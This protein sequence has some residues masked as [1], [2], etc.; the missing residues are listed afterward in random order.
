MAGKALLMLKVKI[1][2]RRP[3]VTLHVYT[4]DT[5]DSLVERC[6]FI[7]NLEEK[8]KQSADGGTLLKERLASLIEREIN[9]K[10]AEMQALLP[11]D[12]LH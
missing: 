1:T 6:L 9:N 4:D 12:L 5:P 2:G 10:I 8:I 11:E 7:C 3:P